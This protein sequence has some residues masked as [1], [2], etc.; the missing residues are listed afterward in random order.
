ML[1]GEKHSI[2]NNKQ[3]MLNNARTLVT[4]CKVTRVSL[5]FLHIFKQQTTLFALQIQ[6]HN[7]QVVM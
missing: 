6:Y 3:S 7:Q 5:L 2:Q 1:R 4:K